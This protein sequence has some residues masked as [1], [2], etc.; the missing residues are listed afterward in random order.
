MPRV[1]FMGK[2]KTG[3]KNGGA[4]KYDAR[5]NMCKRVMGFHTTTRL[6]K[7]LDYDCKACL[8]NPHQLLQ[9]LGM[10]SAQSFGIVVEI[11]AGLQLNRR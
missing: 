2:K 11:A 6:L 4:E 1:R 7:T 8:P 5:S 10:Y 9:C 3:L